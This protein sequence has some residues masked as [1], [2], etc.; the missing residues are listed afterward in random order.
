MKHIYAS[1]YP[2]ARFTGNR[3]SHTACMYA[4]CMNVNPPRE[5]CMTRKKKETFIHIAYMQA[6]CVFLF[7]VNLALG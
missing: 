5:F 7:P 3:K 4:M 1:Y 2:K 6:V